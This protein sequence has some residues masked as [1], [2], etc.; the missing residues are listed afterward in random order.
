MQRGLRQSLPGCGSR[1]T[2]DDQR[3]ITVINKKLTVVPKTFCSP[4]VY[5]I[6]WTL[7]NRLSK[8]SLGIFYGWGYCPFTDW[9]W[10][11]KRK[12]GES[13]LPNSYVKYYVD[14]LTGYTWDPLAVD[15]A[16]MILGILALTL[17]CWLNLRDYSSQDMHGTTIHRWSVIA[18]F[19][20]TNRLTWIGK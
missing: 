3:T 1:D 7:K 17:S 20:I 14:K 9:H 16:V 18:R 11:V 5:W 12:L 4:V 13:N 8:I 15:A 6:Y 19:H 10:E 2:P